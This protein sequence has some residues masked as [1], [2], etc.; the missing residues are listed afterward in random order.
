[1]RTL[2][3]GTMGGDTGTGFRIVMLFV[4]LGGI[5]IVSEHLVSL[6]MAQLSENAELFDVFTDVFDPEGAEIYLKPISDYVVLGQPVNFYAVTEAAR[7]RG[8]TAFGYRLE[9]EAGDAGKSYGVHTNPKKS[10]K[11]VFTSEDKVIVIAES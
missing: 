3:S 10:D 1:M 6:M 8:E 5:F 7:T 9:S 4:S 2:D 11:V